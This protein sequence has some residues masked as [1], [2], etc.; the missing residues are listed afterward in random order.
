MCAADAVS[1]LEFFDSSTHCSR[2]DLDEFRQQCFGE[3]HCAVTVGLEVDSHVILVG[4]RMQVLNPGWG[5][6]DLTVQFIPVHHLALSL[7]E[8]DCDLLRSTDWGRGGRVL[9]VAQPLINNLM[10]VH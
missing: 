10:Q 5:Q 3:E 2:A 8:F 6:H 7:R 4:S 1:G 9:E